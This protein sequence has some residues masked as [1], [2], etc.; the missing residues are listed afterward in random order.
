MLGG[1]G[2]DPMCKITIRSQSKQSEPISGS[3]SLEL[4]N[5]LAHTHTLSL[6]HLHTVTQA[7]TGFEVQG[8]LGGLRSTIGPCQK[9]LLP[10]QNSSGPCE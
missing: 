7:K 10:F 8:L 6:T 4:K 2:G 5:S 9:V 1:G 3:P